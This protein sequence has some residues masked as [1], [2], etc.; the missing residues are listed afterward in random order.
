MNDVS[1]AIRQDENY[2]LVLPSNYIHLKL[3]GEKRREEEIA[4]VNNNVK[5]DQIPVHRES[6]K[7]T[8]CKILFPGMALDLVAGSKMLQ[9]RRGIVE[10][11]SRV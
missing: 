9:Q 1:G 3:H 10:H 4:Q 5:S 11:A 2:Y 8:G 6:N 7:C